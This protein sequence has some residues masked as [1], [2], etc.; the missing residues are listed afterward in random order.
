[1]CKVLGDGVVA[2]KQLLHGGAEGRAANRNSL[3][4]KARKAQQKLLE[5][6][7]GRNVPEL[8]IK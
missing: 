7:V 2:P 5:V 1:M 3:Q 4:N 8:F 6:G